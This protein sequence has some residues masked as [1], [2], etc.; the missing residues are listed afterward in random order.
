MPFIYTRFH[1]FSSFGRSER[2]MAAGQI[3]YISSRWLVDS[4]LQLFTMFTWVGGEGGR[5]KAGSSKGGV[6]LAEKW[7]SWTP[8]LPPFPLPLFVEIQAAAG[9]HSTPMG[10]D[11]RGRSGGRAFYELLA[12]FK[13]VRIY[14]L[15]PRS[16]LLEARANQEIIKGE[17]N[18]QLSPSILSFLFFL[19]A[20]SRALI[21]VKRVKNLE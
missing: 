2:G 7:R 20:Q 11:G 5:L 12:R 21:Q 19:V 17:S 14:I 6:G 18:R 15:Q 4:N 10:L 9:Y 1:F 8:S 13:F 3:L 16:R